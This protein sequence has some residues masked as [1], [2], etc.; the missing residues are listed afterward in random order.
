MR[1]TAPAST[2]PP[3][4]PTAR[5]APPPGGDESGE[6]GVAEREQP[7]RG[8]EENQPR[9]PVLDEGFAVSVLASSG[10]QRLFPGGE[11]AQPAQPG[12]QRDHQ[13]ERQVHAAQRV[14][15]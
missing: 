10:S 7:P 13:R 3:L 4:P 15:P 2:R 11:R 5:P 1:A 8:L 14:S 9:Q 12:L 6:Q